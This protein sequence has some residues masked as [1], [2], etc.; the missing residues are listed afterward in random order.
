MS[1]ELGV[2]GERRARLREVVWCS[3][4]RCGM[5]LYGVVWWGVVW[6]GVVWCGMVDCCPCLCCSP[7][8]KVNPICH[9]LRRGRWRS[10][11]GVA[12]FLL[13]SI[14]NT[15]RNAHSLFQANNKPIGIRWFSGCPGAPWE[16]G[17]PRSGMKEIDSPRHTCRTCTES[18]NN[19]SKTQVVRR[20]LPRRRSVTCSPFTP[21]KRTVRTV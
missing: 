7:A 3:V 8:R 5:V 21:S 4:V 11:R 10:E 12:C 13:L 15:A 16:V 14:N 9:R 6:Y 18:Y 19:S 20:S 1:G 2:C 17:S